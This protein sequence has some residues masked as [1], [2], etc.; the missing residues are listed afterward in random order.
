[1]HAHVPPRAPCRQQEE[2]HQSETPSQPLWDRLPR[3]TAVTNSLSRPS[4][5]SRPGVT[6]HVLGRHAMR[7]GSTLA[8]ANAK[9]PK[10]KA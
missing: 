5:P 1:M 2:G 3:W 10:T 8:R 9:R 4:R 7:G 6:A